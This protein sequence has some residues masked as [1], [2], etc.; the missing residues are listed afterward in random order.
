M[1]QVDFL[2]AFVPFRVFAFDLLF[3]F[4]LEKFDGTVGVLVEHL[5]SMFVVVDLTFPFVGA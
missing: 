4:F 5:Y 3:E 2:D 1:S